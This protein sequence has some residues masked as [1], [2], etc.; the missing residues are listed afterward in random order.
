[1]TMQLSTKDASGSTSQ[2]ANDIE[3]LKSGASTLSVNTEVLAA[4]FMAQDVRMRD[5][6]M[7]ELT[8]P[9]YTE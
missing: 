5:M 9:Y 3:A 7:D 8:R 4:N 2:V 6:I 1:M